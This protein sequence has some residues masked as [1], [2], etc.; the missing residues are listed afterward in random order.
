VTRAAWCIKLTCVAEAL[1]PGRRRRLIEE[2]LPLVGSIARRFAH[3]GEPLD[4]LVQVGTIGLINAVDRFDPGR[5]RALASYAV[6][7]IEG[8][9]QRH[10]RDRCA[11]VRVPR[12]LQEE[13]VA[14]R[15]AERALEVELGRAPTPREVAER[16][17]ISADEAMLALTAARPAG[18][19]PVPAGAGLPA[20]ADDALEQAADRAALA[21]ALAA[22]GNRERL[23]VHLRYFGDMTQAR[24]AAELGLSQNHVSELIAGALDVLR[25][26]M[27]TGAPVPIAPGA[28]SP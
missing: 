11:V 26:E 4:D 13:S 16:A 17:G 23:I 20:A 28:N 1:T 9:I 25:A 14:L 18:P 15:G 3:R 12:R 7:G 6:P 2:H 27:G 21:G 19:L 24:I 10:L 8:E 5:G 22:L